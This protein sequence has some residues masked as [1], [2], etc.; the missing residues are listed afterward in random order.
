MLTTILTNTLN[1]PI[2]SK[3]IRQEKERED[4]LN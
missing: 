1:L 3:T 2:K 4:V